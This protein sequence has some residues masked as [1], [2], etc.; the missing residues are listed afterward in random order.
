[1]WR[2][3]RDD[4][5]GAVGEMAIVDVFTRLIFA[6]CEGFGPRQL[7]IVEA[8]R[9]GDASL[10]AATPQELGGYLRTLGVAEMIRLVTAIRARL[11]TE[12]PVTPLASGALSSRAVRPR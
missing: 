9:A 6:D 4:G 3:E 12:P 8:L 1:M 7:R 10:L 2:E 5:A 11:D